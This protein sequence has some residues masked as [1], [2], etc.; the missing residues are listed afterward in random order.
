MLRCAVLVLVLGV[1]G[2]ALAFWR[3]S[4]AG[5]PGVS[6]A[7][8]ATGVCLVGSVGAFLA[9]ALMRSP[10][11]VVGGVLI[12]MMFRMGLPL[13]ILLSTFQGGGPLIAAGLVTC[14][15]LCY[16]V[17]LLT[18]TLLVLPLVK[19]RPAPAASAG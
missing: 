9:T 17:G 5:R 10:Q 15:L 2:A 1:V 16:P 7:L 18:E 13:V 12:G 14:F 3:Y 19:Q 4:E 8:L 6:A 11:A